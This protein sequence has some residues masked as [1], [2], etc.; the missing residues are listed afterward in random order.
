M[1]GFPVYPCFFYPYTGFLLF[2]PFQRTN[3]SFG[4]SSDSSLRGHS[5]ISAQ[6]AKCW[7]SVNRRLQLENLT[8]IFYAISSTHYN[9]VFHS[10]YTTP[11]NAPHWS[12]HTARAQ[13][14]KQPFP[15]T[16][17]QGDTSDVF[18]IGWTRPLSF[19]RTSCILW[20]CCL[21]V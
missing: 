10:D 16:N 18:S 4:L 2:F 5:T 3:I 11:H 13:F 7:D 15:R 6:I 19:A 8:T 1:V 14:Y 17:T 21:F 9:K 12:A 20:K